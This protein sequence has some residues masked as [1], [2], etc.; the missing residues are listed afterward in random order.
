M[1]FSLADTFMESC[2]LPR[3]SVIVIQWVLENFEVKVA[4]V[5]FHALFLFGFRS[6]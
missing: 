4:F 1:R 5:S 3:F 6:L 2:K